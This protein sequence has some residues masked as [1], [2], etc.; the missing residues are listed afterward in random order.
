MYWRRN[1]GVISR[2][3]TTELLTTTASAG[4]TP[5]CELGLRRRVDGEGREIE[6][7]RE[8]Q[9]TCHTAAICTKFH[10]A[11]PASCQ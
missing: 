11:S 4:R 7:E 10:T 8:R 5:L 9:R 6:R 1:D 3:R 2:R